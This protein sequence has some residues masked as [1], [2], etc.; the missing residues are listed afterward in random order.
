MGAGEQGR[1][2]DILPE[3]MR[4]SLRIAGLTLFGADISGEADAIGTAFRTAFAHIGR[5]MNGPQPPRWLPT[6]ENRRLKAAKGLLDRL[7]Q[8]MID[9]RRR[10]TR[11]RNDLIGMLLAAQ[12]DETGQGMSDR[13]VK[14]EVLTLLTAGHET[15]GAALSWTWY[16]L[17]Q[18][19]EIQEALFDEL[20]GKLNGRNPTV[21]DLPELPLTRATFEEALRLYPPRRGSRGWPSAT[22]RSAAT[23]SPRSRRS[24]SA[25]T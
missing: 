7:V 20:R 10:D 11:E 6:A 4:L 5:R 3:M 25:S 22:T 18:H 21:A 17:G 24:W 23:G 8:E 16:L 14:D 19:P 15:G 2:L 9:N 12:D 13:Q 1:R